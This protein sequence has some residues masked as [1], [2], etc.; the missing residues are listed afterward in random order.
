MCLKKSSQSFC[1]A[2]S[3]IQKTIIELIVANNMKQHVHSSNDSTAEISRL[4]SIHLTW[5]L[6]VKF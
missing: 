4:I 1:I 6:R 5:A 2:F 3:Y